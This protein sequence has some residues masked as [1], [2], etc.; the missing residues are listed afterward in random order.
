MEE[1][2]F[3]HCAER[4]EG[5]LLRLQAQLQQL[6]LGGL[7]NVEPIAA[8]FRIL[9]QSPSRNESVDRTELFTRGS[10]HLIVQSTYCR[11]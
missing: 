7:A 1:L 2:G 10:L 5:E 11:A 9:E 8:R 6:P 3:G 4:A